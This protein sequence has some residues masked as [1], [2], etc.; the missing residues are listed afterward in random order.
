VVVC[1]GLSDVVNHIVQWFMCAVVEW[2]GVCGVDEVSLSGV[3]L[4]CV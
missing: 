3:V 4:L 1:V 2:C